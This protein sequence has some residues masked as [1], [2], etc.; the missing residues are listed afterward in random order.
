M[1][2]LAALA[3]V[4]SA[5]GGDDA[6]DKEAFCEL[7]R[8]GVG[9]GSDSAEVDPGDFARLSE[10]APPE[11]RDAVRQLANT[12][13]SLDEIPDAEL[14]ELFAAAFDPEAVAAR[15][16]LLAYAVGT[17]GVD[18]GDIE[19]G[20]ISNDDVLITEVAGYL[21]TNF[22]SEP[23]LDDIRIAMVRDDSVLDGVTV[24]FERR[25]SRNEAI[26]VCNAVSVW[27]YALKDADGAVTVLYDGAVV[28]GRVGPDA[29]CD[30]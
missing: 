4:L 25:T 6:G 15:D 20:R 22:A 27:L 9:I 2:G 26:D 3:A 18:A 11:I 21:Q 1:V 17:C 28:A 29:S 23:W 5:C 19:G 10:V 12:A 16:E 14:D 13:R 8:D 7:L 30:Q 24:T